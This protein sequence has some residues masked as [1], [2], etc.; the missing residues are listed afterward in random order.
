M[1]HYR[2]LGTTITNQNPIHE[3]IKSRLKSG[4]AYYHSVQNLV[5]SSLLSKN[6]KIETFRSVILSVVLYGCETWSVSLREE[7]RLMV[8]ENMVLRKI[9]GPKRDEARGH[10]RRLH[11]DGLYG[12]HFSPNIIR[13]IN[14]EVCYRRGM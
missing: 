1:E 11:K 9:F 10:W 6:I 4:T 13:V 8:F 2:Y 7:H 3:E 5:F 14:Q 12:L